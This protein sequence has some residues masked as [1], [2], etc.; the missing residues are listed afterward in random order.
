MVLAELGN[1]ITSALRN[2]ANST[3]IDKDV[4]DSMLKEI[5]NALMAADVQFSLVV[6]LRKNLLEKIKLDDMAAG[7]N[8]RK[9]IQQVNLNRL[10][11][12]FIFF[13][14]NSSLEMHAIRL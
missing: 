9:I 13:L 5:S 11:N 10:L 7:L 2:M 3:V 4:L 6:K 8:K 14:S 1:K 12:F